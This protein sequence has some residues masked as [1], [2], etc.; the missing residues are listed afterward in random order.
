MK[1][2]I[3]YHI[4][5]KN[6]WRNLVRDQ[7]ITLANSKL[8]SHTDKFFVGISGRLVLPI[9]DA[10]VFKNYEED[11]DGTLQRL[12]DF[13][14]MNPDY[15]V[16]YF[17]TKGASYNVKDHGEKFFCINDWRKMMEYFC[18]ENWEKA[19]NVL[20]EV[21]AVGINKMVY[22][23]EMF[24]GNFWW[25]KAKYIKAC[26]ELYL[27]R[28]SRLSRE[29]FIGSGHGNLKSLYQSDLEDFSEHYLQ[30]YPRELYDKEF[31]SKKE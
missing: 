18:I 11:E 17:H 1:I 16:L 10:I 7:L 4:Y 21:D 3:F 26:N 2:A 12:Y 22:N 20:E 8:L 9:Q 13:C 5:Q 28:F 14:Y 29:F 15:Y 24:S 25:A 30:R 6:D 31:S 19:L 23:F 27:R